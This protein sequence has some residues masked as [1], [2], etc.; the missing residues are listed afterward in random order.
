MEGLIM[1]TRQASRSRK[2]STTGS[3]NSRRGEE[4]SSQFSGVSQ[5]FANPAVRYVASGIAT[6]LL[7]KLATNIADR[8][9]QISQLLR[10]GMESVEGKL[11]EFN[12]AGDSMASTTSSPTRTRRSASAS[13]G[14]H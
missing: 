3:T 14:T 9:P 8:Y 12:G 13:M 7:T 11:A 10:E 5:W 2:S 1:A 6:A 4:S